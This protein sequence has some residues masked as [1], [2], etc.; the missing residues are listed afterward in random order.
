MAVRFKHS[1]SYSTYFCTFTC[2]QWLPLF[3]ITNTYD[4]VYK[5]FNYLKEKEVASVIAY[6]I[7]PNHLHCILYF[8]KE[9]FEL[10]KIIGNAKRFMAYE[11]IKKLAAIQ[12]VDILERLTENLT[13]REK[14]KGQRHRVFE[15]SFDAKPI[16]S[17]KFLAQKISYIHLNPISKKWSLANDHTKYIHSSA[18]FYENN[19]VKYFEPVH[20]KDL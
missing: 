18:S 8:N 12:R 9:N 19:E 11:I 14:S 3:E 1:D 16:Y 10:N 7:M 13:L 2:Y 17:E 5:W 15:E 4:S 6:V 20:Y